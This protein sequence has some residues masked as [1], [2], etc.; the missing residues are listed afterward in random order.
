MCG[1]SSGEIQ[2]LYSFVVDAS[3]VL[4]LVLYLRL[5]LPLTRDPNPRLGMTHGQVLLATLLRDIEVFT[6]AG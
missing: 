1:G 6:R 4:C 3:N 5:L 2:H